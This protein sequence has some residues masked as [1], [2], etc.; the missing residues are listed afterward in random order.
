M[1][2]FRSDL[3]HHKTPPLTKGRK[4]IQRFFFLNRTNDAQNLRYPHRSASKHV[5]KIF[6]TTLRD[7]FF[8]CSSPQPTGSLLD[9]T[10]EIEQA[11]KSTVL[12]A[13]VV[14]HL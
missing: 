10:G 2:V 5:R 11:Q 9:A 6:C 14:T 4:P 3:P 7:P 1:F 12:S 13:R 8:V